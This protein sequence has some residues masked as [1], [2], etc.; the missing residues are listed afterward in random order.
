[1]RPRHQGSCGQKG[2]VGAVEVRF[3]S[4]AHALSS[5]WELGDLALAS[6]GW[7]FI[8]KAQALCVER[9]AFRTFRRWLCWE[10]GEGAQARSIEIPVPPRA[11]GLQLA[12]R[13]VPAFDFQP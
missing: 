1:M 12:V 2:H 3:Q 5:Q 11:S 13:S 8:T 7:T 10:W 4:G 9:A 6:A